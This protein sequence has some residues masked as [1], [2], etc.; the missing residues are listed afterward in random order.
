MLVIAAIMPQLNR[1]QPPRR[2]IVNADDFGFDRD[3]SH[4]IV[5]AHRRGVVTS[6]SLMVNM[7]GTEEAVDLARQNPRLGVGLHINLTYGKPLSPIE[8]V[9]TLVAANGNFHPVGKFLLR[10]HLG[11][12]SLTELRRE[13][14]AQFDRFFSFEIPCTHFDGHRHIH[15]VP[16]VFRLAI[17]E[18]AKRDVRKCRISLD[19]HKRPPSK[20]ALLNPYFYLQQSKAKLLDIWSNQC[21]QMAS[22]NNFNTPQ[23]FYGIVAMSEAGE[24]NIFRDLLEACTGDSNEIMCHP[25]LP[26]TQVLDLDGYNTN[27]R[28]RDLE[29]LMDFE[30]LAAVERNRLQ[31]ISFKEL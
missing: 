2:V 26:Q 7:P 1:K 12:I 23:A 16:K 28:K 8:T 13:I 19:A 22:E 20:T 18:A 5:E 31:L 24:R 3:I 15:C 27:L 11:R 4:G 21:K 14:A 25:G 10:L 29:Q 17:D 6:T 9:P 30:T